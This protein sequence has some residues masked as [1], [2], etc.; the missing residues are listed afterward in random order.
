MPDPNKLSPEFL[1]SLETIKAVFALYGCPITIT[2]NDN[3]IGLSSPANGL[4]SNLNDLGAFYRANLRNMADQ[5]CLS[6]NLQPSQAI[7]ADWVHAYCD[8]ACKGATA[9]VA[10][11]WAELFSHAVAEPRSVYKRTLTTLYH[12]ET[13][14]LEAFGDL[15]SFALAFESG[16]P[17]FI[18]DIDVLLDLRRYLLGND[19][20]AHFQQIG[21]L[22]TS[23]ESFLSA[24]V[25][26]LGITYREVKY[27]LNDPLTLD[28]AVLSDWAIPYRRLTTVGSQL[29]AAMELKPRYGFV[30]NTANLLS[31]R[32]IPLQLVCDRATS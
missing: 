11:I 15:C 5:Q 19:F 24:K 20:S 2:D 13:W 31:K 21:L 6:R 14:E 18:E 7:T 32:G 26:G 8:L 10:K 17:F 9:N 3:F 4:E 16:T 23:T 30:R 28:S 25:R 22:E 1:D 29:A 12:L 27:V